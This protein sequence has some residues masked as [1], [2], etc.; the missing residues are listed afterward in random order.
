MRR[1]PRRGA[2]FPHA[3]VRVKAR[4]TR[5]RR[6]A[7]ARDRSRFPTASRVRRVRC[8]DPHRPFE[9]RGLRLERLRYACSAS[10]RRTPRGAGE[11]VFLVSLPE[12]LERVL[13]DRR[14]HEEPVVADPL[15]EAVVDERA[16][17]V[18]VG[19]AHVL[20]RYE[21]ERA[22]EDREAG[23]QLAAPRVEQLVAPLD[24]RA[25][26]LLA[27]G[28]RVHRRSGDRAPVESFESRPAASKFVR[29]AA[30]S[31]A[32][33]R[34][35]RRRQIS[36]TVASVRPRAR[37][38]GPARRRAGG[39]LLRKRLGPYSCSP[40]PER[41][42][43]RDDHPQLGAG[44]EDGADE[45]SGGE[46]VLEVVEKKQELTPAEDAPSSSRA[47][48][49]GRSPRKGAR[50]QREPQAAP[51]KR[52]RGGSTS[53]RRDLERELVLPVPPGPVM[54][55]RRVPFES[56]ADD[57]LELPLAADDGSRRPEVRCVEVSGGKSPSPSWKSRSARRGPGG[58]A[59]RGLGASVRPERR[60]SSRR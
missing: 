26:C 60:R 55:M 19:A 15:D 28:A 24:R 40:A 57:I 42:P 50:D 11:L 14:E 32:S 39:L 23:E 27:L 12:P 56:I 45:G 58:G 49:V 20:G 5:G 16:E 3:P 44:A 34:P 46:E 30:S 36:S 29:A 2:R 1:A 22:R 10:A 37:P 43:T 54:V 18:E 8:R 33:G 47:P 41:L 7:R 25:H 6:R 38:P 51:R 17:V 31:T 59:P 21:W 52:R 53:S 9:P 35:S 13:A 48:I 4:T